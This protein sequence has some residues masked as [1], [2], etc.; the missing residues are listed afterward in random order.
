MY[1]I[2]SVVSEKLEKDDFWFF[3]SYSSKT[4][5]L[6]GESNRFSRSRRYMPEMG[7]EAMYFEDLANDSNEKI[8]Q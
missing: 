2:I 1:Y 8:L 6:V 7:R 5:L 4:D 3:L